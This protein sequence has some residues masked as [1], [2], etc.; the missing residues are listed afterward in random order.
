MPKEMAINSKE[1]TEESTIKNI[2]TA[3]PNIVVFL[4]NG[5]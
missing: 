4:F 5:L 2:I 3:F 1:R